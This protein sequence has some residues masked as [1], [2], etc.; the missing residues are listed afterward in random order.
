VVGYAFLAN[1]VGVLDPLH[2][3]TEWRRD[4]ALESRCLVP[5]AEWRAN[6]RDHERS[7]GVVIVNKR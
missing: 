1:K 7:W 2:A 6:I 5:R 4:D 3:V